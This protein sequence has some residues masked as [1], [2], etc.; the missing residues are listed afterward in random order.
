MELISPSVYS[1]MLFLRHLLDFIL[2]DYDPIRERLQIAH[3]PSS[4]L[5]YTV[6]S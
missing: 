2:K 4:P 3:L 5:G 1:K 6:I